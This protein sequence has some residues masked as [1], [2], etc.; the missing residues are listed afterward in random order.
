MFGVLYLG[1]VKLTGGSRPLESDEA[2]DTLR[3][4][5]GD[6]ELRNDFAAVVR[7]L[8][9]NFESLPFSIRSL[10]RDEQRSILSLIWTAALSEAEAA[11]RALHD[12]YVPLVKLHSDL[13]VP[14]P[15]VLYAAAE[16]DLNLR[17]RRALERDDVPLPLVDS[18]LKQARSEQVSLDNA[19]LAFAFKQTLDRAV[20]RFA[21]TP[22]DLS[23]LETLYATVDLARSLPFEIDLGKAQN[24][25][26]RMFGQTR[27]R[28]GG[29]GEAHERWMEL[30]RALGPMLSMR[31]ERVE[32]SGLVH[33]A[34]EV[35]AKR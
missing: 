8:D 5:L 34:A 23:T 21:A 7:L 3:T 35:P 12:R 22:E 19:S 1:D 30:F 2:Y 24:A 26:Y 32:L 28:A 4:G 6:P 16:A 33:Q 15:K 11:F 14:L 27:A 25:Y 10:F 18:L 17:L 20:A 29:N 9:R 13:S 31:Q